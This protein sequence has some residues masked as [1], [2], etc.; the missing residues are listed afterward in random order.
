MSCIPL[1]DHT[2]TTTFFEQC[3]LIL[4]LEEIFVPEVLTDSDDTGITSASNQTTASQQVR[5]P[6]NTYTDGLVI[7]LRPSVFAPGTGQIYQDNDWQ[8]N[9]WQQHYG[10][11]QSP[12]AF[13]NSNPAFA[14]ISNPGCFHCGTTYTPVWR[15]V[16]NYER[17]CNACGLYYGKVR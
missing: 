7:H 5:A 15:N 8:A 12:L 4:G 3:E 13:L 1:Y 14:A 16:L 11:H 17:A 9:I 10:T 6:V 2:V